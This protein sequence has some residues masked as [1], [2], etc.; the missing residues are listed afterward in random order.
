MYP[1]TKKDLHR[2]ETTKKPPNVKRKKK[3]QPKQK[4]NFAAMMDKYFMYSHNKE[5]RVNIP[6]P[7][8]PDTIEQYQGSLHDAIDAYFIN[9]MSLYPQISN[10]LLFVP[11]MIYTYNV[12]DPQN[13]DYG[14]I[15]LGTCICILG[16][17]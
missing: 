1:E 12:N 9:I 2:Q 5:N 14:E 7:S 15:Y 16:K 4:L 13:V 10:Q 11:S 6:E 8:I 17:L 3:T